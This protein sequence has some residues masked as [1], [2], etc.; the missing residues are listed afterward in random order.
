MGDE[1]RSVLPVGPM[2]ISGRDGDES[3]KTKQVRGASVR[4]D[5]SGDK[6]RGPKSDCIVQRCSS[7]E[8]HPAMQRNQPA[9][10]HTVPST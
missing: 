3:M 2:V 1:R 7:N 10:T 6:R 5:A 9:A 4:R 8:E